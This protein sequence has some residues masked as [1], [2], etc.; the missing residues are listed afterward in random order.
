MKIPLPMSGRALEA[1]TSR[2]RGTLQ[3][4]LS[5]NR[6]FYS[7]SSGNVSV[8]ESLFVHPRELP[9]LEDRIGQRIPS[10]PAAESA[11]YAEPNPM[12][13]DIIGGHE[14]RHGQVWETPAFRLEDPSYLNNKAAAERLRSENWVDPDDPM[15]AYKNKLLTNDEFDADVFGRAYERGLGQHENRP[16]LPHSEMMKL[17]LIEALINRPRI[18]RTQYPLPFNFAQAPQPRLPFEE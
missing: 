14:R 5:D 10:D 18:T 17:A 3:R 13:A 2:I 4:P 1:L 12:L 11:F 16:L 6:A 15:A 9:L 8:P 7:K